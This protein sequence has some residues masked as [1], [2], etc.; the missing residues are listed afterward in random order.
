[1]TW[2]REVSALSFLEMVIVEGL[3]Q[4]ALDNILELNIA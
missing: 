1:M 2:S 3:G 4:M